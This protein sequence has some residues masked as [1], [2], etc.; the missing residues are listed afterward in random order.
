MLFRSLDDIPALAVTEAE[1]RLLSNGGF[2]PFVS[3]RVEPQGVSIS[4]ETV[5]QAKSNGRLT[6]LV[7]VRDGFVRPVRVIIQ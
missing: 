5:F 6:A 3:E 4:A 2:L 1:A 7:R